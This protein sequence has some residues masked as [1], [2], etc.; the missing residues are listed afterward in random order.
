MIK[1]ERDPTLHRYLSLSKFV[2]RKCD[3]IDTLFVSKMRRRRIMI[4]SIREQMAALYS[5]DETSRNNVTRILRYVLIKGEAQTTDERVVC[6]FL[7]KMRNTIFIENG[8]ENNETL[9]DKPD[10][11][12]S[13]RAMQCNIY[14]KGTMQ[15]PK[16]ARQNIAD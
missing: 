10:Q 9:R 1:S 15:K 12:R 3:Q 5:E 16:S 4:L 6:A 7:S 14:R 13:V 8:I 2:I 11:L